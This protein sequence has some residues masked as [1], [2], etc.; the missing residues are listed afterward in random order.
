M[1]S[2][3][4][5]V[6]S[7]AARPRGRPWAALDAHRPDL[8][9]L[10]P[11]GEDALRRL[12]LGPQP[13]NAGWLYHGFVPVDVPRDA[14]VIR[15]K[16]TD[17]ERVLQRAERDHRYSG[18]YGLSVFAAA[19]LPGEAEPDTIDRLLR[20]SELANI[21]PDSN[22]RYYVCSR[23]GELLD[24]GFTFTKDG[25]DDEVAEHYTVDLGPGPT[26][27]ETKSFVQAFDQGRRR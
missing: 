14:I 19:P 3:C 27:E 18:T 11:P 17:P 7:G 4:H 6:D 20:A 2:K 26:V 22:P 24:R 8:P 10:C 23:A 1:R 15:F 9:G 5:P 12:P 21:R 25:D 16:P 13:V